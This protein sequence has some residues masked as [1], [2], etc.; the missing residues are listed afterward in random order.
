MAFHRPVAPILCIVVAA[1]GSDPEATSETEPDYGSHTFVPMEPL[2]TE[3][4][5]RTDR[6]CEESADP[7]G[8]SDK[9][10]IHCRTEGVAFAPESP[11][12]KR[13]IVVMAYNFERGLRLDQQLQAFLHDPRLP[14]PDILIVSEIDR[15]CSRSGNRNVLWDLAEALG[16]NGVFAVEFMELPRTSGSGGEIL[17]TC[18]HGNAILSK[19]P[20]GNIGA[21]RHAS[22]RSWY[23][24]PDQREDSEPRLGGR[25]LVHADVRVGHRYVHVYALH[26]ESNP[27]DFEI[28]FEQA[29]E[30]AEHGLA[31]PFQVV[32]GGD[33]NAGLYNLAL[34]WSDPQVDPTTNAYFSRGYVD[35]H[36]SL[37]AEQRGTRG[38]LIIDLLLGKGATS[39]RPAICP[40]EVCADLSDHLPV[41]TTITLR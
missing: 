31:Q 36:R 41:W 15:G 17:E 1:C 26:F 11:E 14:I 34:Q 32:Q 28:Q 3:P 6:L 19:Y 30:A 2:V 37:P 4:D 7:D 27:Q 38:D 5:I 33:T 40:E 13:D 16:M 12:P 10:F 18:E 9:I 20:M 29:I 8:A 25:V 22:N 39:S 23:L 21:V 35:A 24:P